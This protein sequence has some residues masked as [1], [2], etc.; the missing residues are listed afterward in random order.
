MNRSTLPVFLVFLVMGFGDLIGPLVS[1]VK[2]RLSLSQFEASLIAFAGFIM[3]GTLS[4]P[5]GYFQQRFGKRVTVFAGLVLV[6]LGLLTPLTGLMSYPGYLVTVLLLGAGV[7]TLQT[8]GSPL[9][10]ELSAQGA[11]AR[12]LTFGQFVKGIGTLSSPLIPLLAFRYFDNRWEIVFSIFAILTIATLI[13]FGF[14]AKIR[15]AARR[16][17]QASVL[18][19][20]SLLGNA[21]V[22]KMVL[23]IFLYVGAEVCM[24]ATLPALVAQSGY[25]SADIGMAG[26]G[27]FFLTIMAGRFSGTLVLR[28]VRP[29]TFYL[30]SCIIS[31]AGLALLAFG[32]GLLSFVAAC[33]IG[34]GFSNIFPLV[35]SLAIDAMPGKANELSALMV[36]AI[37]GGAVIPPVMGYVADHATLKLSLVIPFACVLYLLAVAIGAARGGKAAT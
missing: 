16:P 17:E 18:S 29:A 14:S 8:A 12:N 9:L 20:F 2:Q 30:W 4:V 36:T 21:S 13:V 7:T 24:S 27:L 5:T 32:Q 22:F 15:Q 25:R 1:L 6:L 37:A 10:H 3:F 11:Y 34:L 31:A 26:V 35:F 23:A 28:A 33:L 19:I